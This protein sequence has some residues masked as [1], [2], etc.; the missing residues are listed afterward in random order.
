MGPFG[1]RG[2]GQLAYDKGMQVLAASQ[3]EQVALEVG[4]LRHGLLTYALLHDGLE[5]QRATEKGEPVTLEKL[6]EYA[7]QRVDSLY[8]EVLT[9]TVR[10]PGTEVANET[11]VVELRE[12][13]DGVQYRQ[14]EPVGLSA[15]DRLGIR[16]HP[17]QRPVLFDFRRRESEIRMT[18]I[19]ECATR[20]GSGRASERPAEAPQCRAVRG[21][22]LATAVATLRS[23]SGVRGQ[24]TAAMGL[25]RNAVRR[26]SRVPA[27]PLHSDAKQRLV[28]TLA[29]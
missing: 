22:S 7:E 24:D 11:R 19:D 25:P 28:V 16:A 4:D 10:G 13:E 1:S 9:G 12:T 18:R 8:A 29:H 21:G 20:G 15:E 27:I 3:S 2:L 23:L 17:I 5:K 14:V 26:R 6:L